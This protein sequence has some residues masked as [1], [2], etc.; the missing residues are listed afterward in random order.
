MAGCGGVLGGP[1]GVVGGAERVELDGLVQAGGAWR[2]EEAAR[3]REDDP[4]TG[5]GFPVATFAVG[6]GG[7]P[8]IWAAFS[9]WAGRRR[10]IIREVHHGPVRLRPQPG[11]G[12]RLRGSGDGG[13]RRGPV[14]FR[15]PTLE[16][17]IV[18]RRLVVH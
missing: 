7:F 12:A 2:V 6:A 15:H 3:V 14:Q 17:T 13:L 8:A 16:K 11:Q 5:P 10:P 1:A 9:V 18:R 4:G